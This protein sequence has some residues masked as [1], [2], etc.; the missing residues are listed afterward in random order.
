MSDMIAGAY[1]DYSLKD[2]AACN[3]IEELAIIRAKLLHSLLLFTRV[4][5]E[6]T[7]GH[8]FRIGTPKGHQSHYITMANALTKVFKGEI[9]RLPI[10]IPPRYGKTAMLIHFVAWS[11]AHYPDCNF[12]YVSYSKDLATHQT[13]VIRDIVSH[14]VYRKIFGVEIDPETSAKDDFKTT[15][16]GNIIAAGSQGTITGYGAGIRGCNRF[17]GCAI[18]DDLHKPDEITSDTVRK[19]DLEWYDGTMKTRLNNGESTP[20]VII[21]QRLHEGDIFHKLLGTSDSEYN[22]NHLCLSA[23]TKTKQALCPEL[24]T[25][26]QLLKQEKENPY[27]FWAQMMQNPQPA[28]GGLYKVAD[29]TE[30]EMPKTIIATFI[31]CDTAE[32][33]KT[34]NDATAFSFWA[35]H[36]IEQWGKDTGVQGLL[37]LDCEQIW[38]EPKDLENSFI[39]FYQKCCMFHVKPQLVAIEKKSTGSTLLSLVRDIRGVRVLEVDRNKMSGSKVQRFIDMQVYIAKK[40]V[41]FPI[42]GAHNLMCKNHMGKITANGT[43]LRD[44]V[45]D[46]CYDAVKIGLIDKI[47]FEESEGKGRYKDLLLTY[48][49]NIND[50]MKWHKQAYH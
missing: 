48:S 31:T 13:T 29:F 16:G 47:L 1:D 26:E 11:L 4:F 39:A 23:I 15:A 45:A 10:N 24:H 30:I 40:L 41:S 14:P 19:G 46:T 38:V 17:G 20:I 3:S 42:N 18:I 44:D 34:Y 28:G 25:Y 2:I 22:K 7:T 43:H 27:Q 8:P 33:S 35:L 36:N 37:W 9:T 12:L 21:G 5:F 50:Q 32:T 6:L 49:E